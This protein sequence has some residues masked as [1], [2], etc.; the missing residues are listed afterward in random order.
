MFPK[1]YRVRVTV[2]HKSPTMAWLSACGST[3][4]YPGTDVGPSSFKDRLDRF[5][6]KGRIVTH[7]HQNL[8][9]VPLWLKKKSKVIAVINSLSI[10]IAT[11][12]LV[13]NTVLPPPFASVRPHHCPLAVTLPGTLALIILSRRPHPPDFLSQHPVMC[14]LKR[15]RSS[16]T[17]SIIDTADVVPLLHVARLLL[18]NVHL[19]LRSPGVQSSTDMTSGSSYSPTPSVTSKIL[20]IYIPVILPPSGLLGSSPG[21]QIWPIPSP[22]PPCLLTPTW[23]SSRSPS[24]SPLHPAPP[25]ASS[26]QNIPNKH[27]VGSS[28]I[29]YLQH[30]I[31][32]TVE[33]CSWT[34]GPPSSHPSSWTHFMSQQIYIKNRGVKAV[35]QPRD[36]WGEVGRHDIVNK[37]KKSAYIIFFCLILSKCAS[38]TELQQQKPD[39]F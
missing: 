39:W 34:S 9:Q 15:Y 19:W 21:H 22:L 26:L 33:L 6:Y 35:F 8:G 38:D 7:P 4:T 14:F 29:S 36:G 3:R 37:P 30:N 17:F 28:A 10:T 5:L 20:L 24:S 25:L 12:S 2:G 31:I 16:P 32:G 1:G 18:S 13:T 27:K 23:I 11:K